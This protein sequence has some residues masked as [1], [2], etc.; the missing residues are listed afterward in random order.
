MFRCNICPY[1]VKTSSFDLT[2]GSLRTQAARCA[3]LAKQTHDEEGRQRYL[4]LEQ[5][6]LELA[7][8]EDRDPA[9][10]ARHRHLHDRHD[11][12]HG[13][14]HHLLWQRFGL[15]QRRLRQLELVLCVPPPGSCGALRSVV[16]QYQQ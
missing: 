10:G 15:Q 14:K 12:R 9:V 1:S 6:Y 7:E 11:M 5:M 16:K 8:T 2:S 3:A 13:R 4:R